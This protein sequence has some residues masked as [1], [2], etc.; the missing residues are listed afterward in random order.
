MRPP[1]RRIVVTGSECTGKTTL[2]RT[3]AAHL[4]AGWVPEQSRGL[5]ES[6]GRPLTAD[7]VEPIARAQLQAE[8]TAILTARTR[9]DSALIHDTDLVSTVVYARHYY[10]A[11][12]SW[13]LA[14]ARARLADDYLLCD[15]DIP[16]E[17]DLVRDRPLARTE[18]HAAFRRTLSEL[19]A[20]PCLV[21]GLGAARLDAA[22]RCLG[23]PVVSR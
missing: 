12:P 21:R 14:T 2:A 1:V 18:L 15:I 19:G 3:L 6:V 20:S 7:D 9:G 23:E 11:C 10:G 22:L 4:G 8:D 17:P 16:W 5:A 13:I